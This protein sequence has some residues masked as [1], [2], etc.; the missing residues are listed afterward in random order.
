MRVVRAFGRQRRETARFVGENHFMTRQELFAWWWSRIVEVVWDLFL[1]AA[2][3]ALLLFGGLGVLDG[4]LSLGDL[5][6][7]LVYLAMLLEPLAVLATSATQFQNNL[8]GFDRVLDLLAEPRE[9]AAQPGLDRRRQGARSPAGSR[10][11]ASA[12]PTRRRRARSS[13]RST[14]TSSPARSIALVGR[15]GRGQDD[16][17]QPDRPVLRPDR[18]R[19][20]GSTASTSATSRSR[21]TGACSGSSSRTS[22]C[23]TARSPRTSPT[24]PGAPTAAEV[25]RAARVAN[26]DEFIEAL[27]DGY[28]TLIGERGVR[29]SGGQRQRLAIARAVL[30]DPTIFILDEATSNL[31]SESE[32]LIQQALAALMRGRTSFVIA[33]RLSTIRSADR[34][35]VLDGG[36]IVEAGTHD[37]L[38]ARDGRYREMVELQ[39]MEG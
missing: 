36:A 1:P 6:M 3:G 18:G 19:R 13:A 10:S 21:A 28:D 29:L 30:A 32:R 37:E 22:S 11:K 2:S 16:A 4:R 7:F 14:S 20:S 38:L 12:S 33:H 39:T 15:S 26:A 24:P 23:S 9:M 31:D 34:I 5:M 25:A 35:L 8:S 17:L 27:P